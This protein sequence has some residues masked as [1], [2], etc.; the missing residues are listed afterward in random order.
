M[1]KIII[2]MAMVAL[3]A[4]YAEEATAKPKLSR[5]ERMKQKAAFLAA[6]EARTGGRV[7]KEGSGSGSFIFINAEKHVGAEYMKHMTSR[8]KK[9]YRV[10]L[11]TA[12]V[13]DVTMKN[14]ADVIA[15]NGATIGLAFVEC[16]E[17]PNTVLLAPEQGWGIVNVKALGK[18]GATPEKVRSRAMKE[19]VRVFCMVATG[20]GSQYPRSL[21]APMRSLQDIDGATNDLIPPDVDQRISNAIYRT[22]V[23]PYV[24][25]TYLMACKEGWA[26]A[27]TNDNQRAIWNKIHELPSDP[28]K[29]KYDPKRD[30]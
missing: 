17:C 13:A 14:V 16:D 2:A 21:L 12:D 26:P 27:P 3:G 6:R 7:V 4:A 19:L 29:I 23:E 25:A 22:G 5:E 1:K 11:K 18:D 9:D 30:K 10:N 20:S 24:E 8:I 28:I 15:K